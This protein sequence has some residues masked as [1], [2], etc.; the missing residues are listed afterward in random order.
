MN[1]TKKSIL[2]VLACVLGTVNTKAPEF[3]QLVFT[4]IDGQKV[5]TVT[6]P[7]NKIDGIIENGAAFDGSSIGG[8]GVINDSDKLLKLDTNAYYEL[9]NSLT[10]SSTGVFFCDVY[11]DTK[12][13]YPSD[14]RALCKEAAKR[15]YDET[16]SI[17]VVGVELEFYLVDKKQYEQGNVE[18]INNSRYFDFETSHFV[19]NFRDDTMRALI[20][21]GVDVEKWHSEVGPAQYE[22]SIKFN[23]IVT[24]A[25]QL[26]L[27]KHII[28][29]CAD[30]ANMK[31][32]FSPKPIKS[33]NGNGLHIHFS[34]WK[35]SK[36]MF[37]TEDSEQLSHTAFQFLAGVM[38]HLPA[39][40][41]IFDSSSASY[42]RLVPGFEAPIFLCYSNK[43]RSAAVRIP[44]TYGSTSA[45]RFE[46][47]C[48]D[49]DCNP[50]IAFAAIALS[51]L[52]GIKNNMVADAP[53]QKNL[54]LL[55]EQEIQNLNI[56]RLP[57]SLERALQ[58]FE[59]S[60]FIKDAFSP[61]F[62]QDYLS[63]VA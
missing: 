18:P 28:A 20:D 11:R 14:P 51:G 34:T 32:L 22:I 46:L 41:A 45:S 10:D 54:Y 8:Y 48:A 43:N 55:S 37:A 49:S 12:E 35:D 61:E 30:A 42:E 23:D 38:E 57:Y 25:D 56:S 7:A 60:T 27:A 29:T 47:R 13:T 63:V 3:Y 21:A 50:Y 1:I 16:G 33:E 15:L 44:D 59:K 62:I 24:L 9:K 6:I 2:F 40:A 31:A 19:D 5:R 4:P 39:T 58:N 53:V 17:L 52:D 36:N 26:I